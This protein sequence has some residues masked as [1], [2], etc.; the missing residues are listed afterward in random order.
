[1]AR[2]EGLR[3]VIAALKKARKGHHA[4]MERGLKK[5]GLFLQRESQKIV[6]VDQNVLRPS[7]FTRPEPERGGGANTSVVVGYTAYYAI[8]VHED[9]NARHAPGTQAK[10]LETPFR[11]KREEMRK[12][13]LENAERK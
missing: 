6:P 12:I 2:V 10:F 9:L 7:A 4:G 3:A 11:E 8:Y 1:M 13:I 5:A